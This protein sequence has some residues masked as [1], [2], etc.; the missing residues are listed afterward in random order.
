MSDLPYLKILYF[1]S[2]AILSW[3]LKDVGGEI[4]EKIYQN[5]IP[6]FYSLN[7]SKTVKEEVA[8]K[9]REQYHNQLTAGKYLALLEKFILVDNSPKNLI[10]MEQWRKDLL[11]GFSEL[12][13]RRHSQDSK[14]I[15]ELETYLEG[16]G[17]KSHPILISCDLLINNICTKKN[18]R[19][20]NPKTGTYE[21]FLSL[22]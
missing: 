20:F 14:I 15:N 9:V 3:F 7:I 13:K 19:V 22:L 5:D 18:H 6:N 21:D 12:Q 17:G 1:D 11:K 16:L 10:R 2:S 4:V 8:R